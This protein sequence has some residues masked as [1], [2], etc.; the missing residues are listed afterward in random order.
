MSF[1]QLPNNKELGYVQE[2]D[3]FLN[4]I[5]NGAEPAFSV[6]DGLKNVQI[7]E[8]FKLVKASKLNRENR[9]KTIE[10]CP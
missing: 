5:L 2:N 3:W 1:A 10:V 9:I 7:I 4:T 6:M 8:V